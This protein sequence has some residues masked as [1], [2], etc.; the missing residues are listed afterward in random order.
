MNQT[1][2]SSRKVIFFL[3]FFH[4]APAASAQH[5]SGEILLRP[6]DG[7]YMELRKDFLFFDKDKKTWKAPKGYKTDGA[8][9]PRVLWSLVGSPFTGHYLK[10]AI[11]HDVYCDL[12]SRD[13]RLVHNMFFEA[14]IASDVNVTQAKIMYY[15]VYRFGPRW[16]VDR[17]IP[18]PL[19]YK[20]WDNNPTKI[21]L[22]AIPE[23]DLAEFIETKQAIE[24]NPESIDIVE[25]ANQQLRRSQRKIRIFGSERSAQD[26]A[27][28]PRRNIDQTVSGSQLT[29]LGLAK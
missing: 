24:K 20:C 18:C 13:W 3:L 29:A 23:V 2:Y 5:F 26:D 14:M 17:N 22:T 27:A 1:N 10:A 21:T 9:I 11:L 7:R 15:A 28:G 12:K 8:S 6:L 4:L 16:V 19:G 25:I